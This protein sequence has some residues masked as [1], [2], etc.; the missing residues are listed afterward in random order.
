MA[1]N[2]DRRPRTGFAT[3]AIHAGNHLNDTSALT[4]PIFQ[5]S[6]FELESSAQGVEFT[7]A[8]APAAFYTRWGNP[9]TK[10]VEAILADLEGAEAALAFSSGMGA[11]SAVLMSLVEA[12]DHLV[13]GRSIYSGTQELATGV[14]PRYGVTS[15][16]VDASDLDAVAAAIDANE[17]TRAVVVESPTNPTLGIT[18]LEA[19]ARLAKQRGVLT[20][21]DNTFATPFNQNPLRLG[22]DIVVHAATKALGGHS[23]LTAGIACSTREIVSRCWPMLKLFG[24]CLS[25]FE[26]WLLLRGLKTLALRVE[27]QNA[28]AMRLARFLDAHPR[29]DRVWYPGL[30]SDGGH[31]LARR[32]MRGFGSIL[33]FEVAGGLSAGE[34]VVES[35][36]L[37]RLAVSLGG[38]ESIVS[39]PASMSH[40]ALSEADLQKAGLPAGLLRLSIGLEDAAD[41]EADLERALAYA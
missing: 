18:D 2:D 29:I 14:F 21:A 12:G 17:R 26:A 8:T 38:A 13:V 5:S 16:L 10:Q 15:T 11:I 22:I 27:R 3:R 31:E 7:Q 6:T 41:L 39:H 4:P 19:L 30:E 28:T 40:G 35:L 24:A 36:E 20:V 32:Q 33:S 1:S 34:H 23:D 37:I 9:T 25:P